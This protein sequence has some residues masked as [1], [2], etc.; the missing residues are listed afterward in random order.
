MLAMFL[1]RC[2]HCSPQRSGETLT[3]AVEVQA[4]QTVPFSHF[5]E[6]SFGSDHAYMTLRFA[7]FLF[8]TTKSTRL[9]ESPRL[10]LH[11]HIAS[12]AA[13]TGASS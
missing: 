11:H 1:A 2:A 7:D 4:D 6:R 13:R 10:R 5:F 8:P 3:A 12:L 9:L